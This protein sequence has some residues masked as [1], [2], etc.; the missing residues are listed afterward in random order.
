MTTIYTQR[1]DVHIRWM[2]RRDMPEVLQIEEQS[3]EFP[4]SEEDF[5]RCLRQ[6]NCICMTAIIGEKIVGYM[7][8]ELHRQRL[9]VLNFAVHAEHR[10]AFV[11][12]SMVAKLYGKLSLQRRTH[13]LA[14][15][16]E[17]NLGA[18]LFFKACGF[19]CVGL[20]RE[21]FIDTDEDAYVFRL[22]YG[23]VA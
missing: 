22:L 3:F 15:V 6:R 7:I 21:Q 1:A 23:D 5:I 16:R 14:R 17:T 19:R 2:I 11:G 12:S 20:L 4:L 8:Y 10:R 18:Q 9:E 13:I